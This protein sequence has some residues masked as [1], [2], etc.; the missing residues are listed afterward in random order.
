MY[1]AKRKENE[2]PLINAVDWQADTLRGVTT[3][4]SS[5]RYPVS[6]LSIS[7]QV[8]EVENEAPYDTCTIFFFDEDGNLKKCGF[9]EF[10]FAVKREMGL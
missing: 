6:K 4:G 5:V 10:A 7:S 8:Q 3:E 2:L 9:I 1:M